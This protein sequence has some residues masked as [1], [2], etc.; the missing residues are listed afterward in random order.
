[1]Q[2]I[3]CPEFSLFGRMAE[4]WSFG[5]HCAQYI[6][7]H[8]D[9]IGLI[10]LNSWPI[11]SQFL[12][13]KEAKRL[14][15]PAIVHI[16]D[17]YPD[18]LLKKIKSNLL[19]KIVYCLFLPVDK[20]IQRNACRVITISENMRNEFL[21]SRGTPS[22]KMVIVANWQDESEFLACKSPVERKQKCVFMYLGNNG[23]VA[24]VDWLIHCFGKA[25][26]SN[27]RLVVAGSGSRKV[28]CM[29]E[30]EKYPDADIHFIDVP[31]GKVPETQSNADVMI[32]A[33]EPGAA[34]SSIPSKIPAYM[35]S[36][37]PLLAALDEESDSA[38]AI[39]D[40]MG[41]VVV[42]PTDENALIREMQK[43]SAM[44][45]IQRKEM[46]EKSFSYAIKH[47]SKQKNLKELCNIIEKDYH[48][49]S[50]N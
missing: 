45:D 38:Q 7:E 30:A 24:R 8:R 50:Q 42:P 6:H 16:Q 2:S 22:E 48:D 25:K 17:I 46:G 11:F 4:S 13:E 41:G 19:K 3:V 18:S 47:F 37:K 33:V 34:L 23:P 9:T 28:Y 20:W 1:M 39:R 31:I 29:K 12:I 26:L 36:K 27:S 40:S 35:F 10:Y 21:R 44:S 49:Y 14:K 32:L 43:F 5:K 15:I